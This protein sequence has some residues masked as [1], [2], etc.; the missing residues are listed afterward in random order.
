MSFVDDQKR[1]SSGYAWQGS[2]PLK[3]SFARRSGRNQKNVYF[4]ISKFVL[5]C[6]PFISVGLS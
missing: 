4:V 2:S 1:E 5:H 3:S 6:L